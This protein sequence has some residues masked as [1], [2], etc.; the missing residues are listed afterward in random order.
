LFSP[1]KWGN[2]KMPISLSAARNEPIRTRDRFA[3][4]HASSYRDGDAPVT[5][6]D[7]LRTLHGYSTR[8]HYR[9]GET[10]FGEGEPA[11]RVYKI[12]AGTVRLCR[13]SPGGR[14][15][16]TDFALAGDLLGFLECSDQPMTAEAVEDVTLIS[17]PRSCVDRLASSN[18]DIRARMMRHLSANLVEAQQQLFVLG[19]QSAKEKLAS[20]LTR[21]AGRIDLAPGETLDLPM[22]RQDIA[23]HLGLTIETVCRTIT[24]LK[25]DGLLSV[26]SSHELVLKNMAALRTLAVE[27]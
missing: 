21:L 25:N 4:I 6:N 20:F 24:A 2:K 17:Y 16:I 22:G 8:H 12:I 18:P 5:L 7:H 19:C 26:P 10:I 23:D 27:N 3:A 9:R 15:H 13:Y 11:D 14:R 1:L